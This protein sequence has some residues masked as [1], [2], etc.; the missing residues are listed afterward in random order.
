MTD[1][2]LEDALRLFEPAQ[3]APIIGEYEREQLAVHATLRRLRSERL[4]REA[5]QSPSTP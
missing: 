2:I 3:A 4:A 5:N 1:Q